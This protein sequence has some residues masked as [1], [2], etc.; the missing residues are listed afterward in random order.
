MSKYSSIVDSK[1]DTGVNRLLYAAFDVV[2]CGNAGSLIIELCVTRDKINKRVDLNKPKCI[3]QRTT[4]SH[5]LCSCLEQL[6]L[7]KTNS[8]SCS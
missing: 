4:S 3:E 6:L 5:Q 7:S 8:A 1:S 2:I